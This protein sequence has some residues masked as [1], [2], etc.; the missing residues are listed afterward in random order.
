MAEGQVYP[1]NVLKVGSFLNHQIDVPFM[2]EVGKEFY[3]LYENDGVNKILTIEA[4][5]IGVACLAAQFS[6]HL[7]FSQR[8]ARL[9]ISPE[10]YIPVR[11]FLLPTAENTT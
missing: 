2:M 5:G 8:K 9:K 10:R 4:S 11:L 6:M 1:G 7:L 3:R